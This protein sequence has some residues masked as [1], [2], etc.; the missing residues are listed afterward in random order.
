MEIEIA[1]ERRLLFPAGDYGRRS[2]RPRQ[3]SQGLGLRHLVAPLSRP[4][5]DDITISD[6][7]LWYLPLWH[8]K[9]HLRFLYDRTESYKIPI[10]TKHVAAVSVGG[11]EYVVASGAIDVPVVEH[12]ERDEQR[13]LWLDALTD[14][15]AN[16]QP[17]LKAN[18]TPVNL[19]DFS[20]K[21]RRSSRQW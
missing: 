14:Q 15:P 9:A 6:Q 7:G 1:R 3:R 4:K 2:A 11:T 5:E 18:A 21:A 13:E 10:K 16:A 8:T 17:Y 12:C 19:D 20:P